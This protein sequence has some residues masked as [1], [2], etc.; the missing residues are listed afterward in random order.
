MIISILFILLIIFGVG[1]PLSLW[2]A[3]RHNI[4]GRL[5]LS[6]LLGI[7]IFTL[8]MYITNLLGLKLTFLNNILVFSILSLPLIFFERRKYRNLWGEYKKSIK[9]FHPGPV[10]KITLGAIIFFII[11]SFASTLYWPVYVWDALTLYD[12]RAHLF[13]QTGFI[14]S[15][16]SALGDSFYFSYPLLTSLAHSIVYLS[17]GWNPQFIYSMFYL[18]LALV[19]YGLARE[20]VSQ[21]ISLVFTLIL[22][23]APRMFEQST[24]SSTNFPYMAY[25]SL[26][27]IYFYVWDKKNR[28]G[29]LILS[30]ILTGLAT[31]TR[32][33]EPFWL[34]MFAIIVLVSI[35]RKRLLDP[36]IFVVFFLP[37]QQVW[38]NFQSTLG[39]GSSTVNEVLTTVSF[40]PEIFRFENWANVLNFIYLNIVRL[41]GPLFILFVAASIM[42]LTTKEQRKSF[43]MVFITWGLLVFF[44]V[45]TFIFSIYVGWYGAISD[46]A[47]RVSMIFY[48]LFVYTTALVF[49]Q[50]EKNE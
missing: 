36:V 37:I 20:F 5:G 42:S 10:E 25:F 19:F 35:Y 9:S 48:P 38:K 29:Y 32:A 12:F 17:G 7:G 30:A 13:T 43:L 47:A 33:V 27:V 8:A 24:I 21:K 39:Q 34:G 15:V 31:W 14:S 4:A 41:W 11:S 6:Y 44:V 1:F 18:S 3:P 45:G 22:L 26:G 16:L 50:I 46:S 23:T 40:L 2:I 28:P 49:F